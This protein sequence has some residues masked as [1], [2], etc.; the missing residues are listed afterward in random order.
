MM[1]K[2]TTLSE[3]TVDAMGLLGEWGLSVLVETDTANILMDA[4]QSLSAGH[5]ASVMGI[6]LSKVDKIVL[7][8]GHSDHTGGLQNVL[9]QMRK[10]VEV[11][12]HPD[13][14]TAKY[15]GQREDKRKDIG[16]PF[17]LKDLES[18][19][20]SFKLSREPVRITDNIMTTGEVPMVTDFEQITPNRFYVKGKSGWQSDELLDDMALIINTKSGLVVVLGCGHRGVINTLY[21]SQKLIGRK[22]VRMVIGGCH[23]INASAE[24]VHMTIAALK[25]LDVQKV[26]MSHCTGLPA[27]AMMAQE[28]G[29][30]FF[31]NNACTQI[32]ITDTEI[33]VD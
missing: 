9:R 1:L 32:D 28:L 12:A 8:H 24:R 25:E 10:K 27:S 3:N 6:D 26:G 30:R 22:E 21:H 19:G 33:K 5:N 15:S 13:V 11:I 4:G 2:I 17:L 18:L 7:S 29:E 20:A 14:W 31:Y 16:M 23:L